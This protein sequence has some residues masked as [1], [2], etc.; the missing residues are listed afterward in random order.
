VDSISPAAGTIAGGTTVTI[1]GTDLTAASAV[2]F[3]GAPATSFTVVSDTQISAIA[4]EHAA[5]AVDVVVTTPVGTATITSGYTY[6]AAPMITGISPAKGPVAGGNTVVVTGTSLATTTALFFG[7]AATSFTIDSDTQITAIVPAG[8]AG[9]ADVTVITAG[10]SSTMTSSYTYV[11]LPAPASVSPASGTTAGGTSVTISGTNLSNA[12]VSFDGTPGTVT[13]NTSTQIVVTTP[14]HGWA[15]QRRS[16]HARRHDSH[17][18]LHLCRCAD[19]DDQPGLRPG[20]SDGGFAD[21]LRR[22]V[23]RAGE[24]V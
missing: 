7:S 14:A 12:T 11:P 15:G 17:Q 2:T 20:R 3:D 8:T 5:G 1:T 21:H 9:A 13:V 16:D 22:G 10:G 6:L 18:Q 24:R 19:S 4:P 23:Q